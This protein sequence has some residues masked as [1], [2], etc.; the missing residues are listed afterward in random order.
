MPIRMSQETGGASYYASPRDSSLACISGLFACSSFRPQRCRTGFERA[1]T[2]PCLGRGDLR[3]GH[4][5]VF[6]LM[7]FVPGGIAVASKRTSTPTGSF[8]VVKSTRLSATTA[9]EL[10]TLQV[11]SP[12]QKTEANE[13]ASII[14]R[15]DASGL[16]APPVDAARLAVLEG[17]SG[18]T[19]VDLD[20]GDVMKF[21]MAARL[22]DFSAVAAT[23]PP[24]DP[25]IGTKLYAV[26]FWNGSEIAYFAVATIT[27][28]DTLY[29][30]ASDD[31]SRG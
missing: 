29:V 8:L 15:T 30:T 28:S 11:F 6:V 5:V 31:G 23:A 12:T 24:P 20:R 19:L 27:S 18:N 21:V 16:P 9:A 13:F 2:P 10:G 7:L 25:L 14:T 1:P 3:W 22:V 26:P 4:P 17:F